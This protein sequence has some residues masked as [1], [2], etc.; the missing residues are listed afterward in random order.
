MLKKLLTKHQD[1][2][3]EEIAI[4]AREEDGKITNLNRNSTG[5]N[6]SK[7]EIDS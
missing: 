7:K 6:L 1:K 5:D 2:L 3:K 4:V